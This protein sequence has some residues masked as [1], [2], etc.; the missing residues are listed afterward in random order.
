MTTRYEIGCHADG[1]LGHQQTKRLMLVYQAGIANVF[2]VD[3]FNL[4]P[5]GREARRVMQH[6]FRPCEDFCRGAAHAGAIVR[7]AFCNQAGDIAGA[8]WDEDHEGAPFSDQIT[9]LHL[10]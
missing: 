10:N 9:P 3:C 6:A 7:T 8:T 2:E 4:A 5:Y 1:A